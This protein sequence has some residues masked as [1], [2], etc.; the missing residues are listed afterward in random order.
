MVKLVKDIEFGN[1]CEKKTP[2][3]KCSWMIHVVL[4]IGAQM[5][6]G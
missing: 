4:L 1:F 6:D 2:M 5:V 3:S